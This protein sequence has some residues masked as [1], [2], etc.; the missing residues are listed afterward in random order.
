MGAW[1]LHKYM[2]IVNGTFMSWQV[3]I[4]SYHPTE[5]LKRTIATSRSDCVNKNREYIVDSGASLHMMRT[6]SE[7]QETVPSS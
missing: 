3:N 7:N 6:P 4:S 5:Q 1:D 2:Y